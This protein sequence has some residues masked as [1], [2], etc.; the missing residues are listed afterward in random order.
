VVTRRRERARKLAL[1]A[2]SLVL[3]AAMC[4]GLP[5]VVFAAS[6]SPTRVPSTDTRSPLEGPGFV[7]APLAA[8]LAVLAIAVLAILVTTIYVR[9]T[10]RNEG[11]PERH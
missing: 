4:L 5:A 11:D 9:L 2:A 7:G 10:A 6:P 1:A 8:L 3:C